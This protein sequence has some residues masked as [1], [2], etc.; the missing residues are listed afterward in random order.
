VESAGVEYF[1][2]R[3]VRLKNNP[4]ADIVAETSETLGAWKS[5]STHTVIHEVIDHLDGTETVV[6]RM[7]E[8]MIG[9]KTGFMRLKIVPK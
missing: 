3:Y 8:P 6:E 7:T 4:S 5:G 9:S 1:A 2:L